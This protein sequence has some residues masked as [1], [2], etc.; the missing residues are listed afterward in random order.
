MM[1][2]DGREDHETSRLLPLVF[3]PVFY[4]T[5]RESTKAGFILYY[6]FSFLDIGG[7]GVRERVVVRQK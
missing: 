1:M 5:R 7:K 4:C 2:K 3:A 6:L